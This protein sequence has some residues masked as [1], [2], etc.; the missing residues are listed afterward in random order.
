MTESVTESVSCKA[1]GRS[2]KH[3]SF[4]KSVSNG[5]CARVSF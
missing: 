5:V 3:K 1:S 4:T 2:C